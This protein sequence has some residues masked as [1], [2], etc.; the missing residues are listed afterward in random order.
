MKTVTCEPRRVVVIG[1]H[2]QIS[3][4]FAAQLKYMHDSQQSF[5]R[6]VQPQ[7]V[8]LIIVDM[9]FVTAM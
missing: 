2:S 3:C 1:A 9:L 5:A 8:Y 7:Q 4:V 6:S